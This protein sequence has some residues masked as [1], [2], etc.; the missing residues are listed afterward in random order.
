MGSRDLPRWD[1]ASFSLRHNEDLILKRRFA[2]ALLL[3]EGEGIV[4]GGE[5][6]GGA[7]PAS[8]PP[9]TVTPCSEI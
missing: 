8:L 5:G 1:K 7:S 3:V 9:F 6:G 4:K 2:F